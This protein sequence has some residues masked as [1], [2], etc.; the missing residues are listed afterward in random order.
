M[1]RL[2]CILAWRRFLCREDK[3]ENKKGKERK[4]EEKE[5]KEPLEQQR[6][7]WRDNHLVGTVSSNFRF[8][9]DSFRTFQQGQPSKFWTTRNEGQKIIRIRLK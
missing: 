7:I 8:P 9:F 1:V 3:R 5:K 6:N 4:G 2:V